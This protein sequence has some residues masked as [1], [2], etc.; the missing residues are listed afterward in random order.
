MSGIRG[1]ELSQKALHYSVFW[2]QVILRAAKIASFPVKF[3]WRQV[4]SALRR[5][6][7]ATAENTAKSTWLGD[8]AQLCDTLPLHRKS[9]PMAVHILTPQGKFTIWRRR[10]PRA[11]AICLGRPHLVSRVDFSIEVLQK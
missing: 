5:Q 7:A 11:L 10:T 4:R 1:E 6:P 2:P 8:Y 3:A 9:R